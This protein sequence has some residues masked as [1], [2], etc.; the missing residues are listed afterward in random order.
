MN[1]HCLDQIRELYNLYTGMEIAEAIKL[2][3][4]ELTAE[5]N[6][7]ELQVEILAKQAA[8]DQLNNN[9]KA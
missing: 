1:Q 3:R 7:H 2:V 6:R 5:E 9:N 8:L 4:A